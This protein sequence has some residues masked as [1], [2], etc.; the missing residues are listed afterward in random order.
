MAN[1][2][3]WVGAHGVG[4]LYP[5]IDGDGHS[6]CSQGGFGHMWVLVVIEKKD[7]WRGLFVNVAL[8]NPSRKVQVTPD[9]HCG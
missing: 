9:P 1:C 7:L 4:L 3:W 2:R 6:S 8:L 5:F